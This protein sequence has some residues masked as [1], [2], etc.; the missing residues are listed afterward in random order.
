[1]ANAY[2][3]LVGIQEGRSRGSVVGIATGFTTER[4]EFE[5]R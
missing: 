2:K 5:S 3:I 4:Y 1:M